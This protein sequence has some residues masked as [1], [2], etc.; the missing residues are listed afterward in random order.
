MIEKSS[1]D[2]M[3]FSPVITVLEGDFKMDKA[4]ATETD[5]LDDSRQ[6]SK[7]KP[8]R[9]V[10]SMQ[11]IT[12]STTTTTSRLQVAVSAQDLDVCS[13]VMKSSPDEKTEFQPVYRS[14]SCAEQGA[15]QFM[16]DEHICIDDLVQHLGSS[17]DFSSLG[18]FYGVSECV[19]FKPYPKESLST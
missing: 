8:P 11:H 10:S 3:D 15:K 12:S 9:H 18:A 14:G 7:G 2:G 1:A 16:E 5:A 4:S 6:M 13:L 17:V 19:I